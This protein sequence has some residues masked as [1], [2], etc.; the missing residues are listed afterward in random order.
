MKKAY[1]IGT[2]DTKAN[3][4]LFVKNCLQKVGVEC[5]TVDVSTVEHA[6]S[7]DVNL[8]E[9]T[10]ER[11]H[12]LAAERGEAIST[13]ARVLTDFLHTCT[14]IA[15]VLGLG[16]S[17]GTALITTA[18][19][20][21]SIGLPKIMV[22]TMASG[23]VRAYVGVSDITMMNSITDINGINSISYKVLSNA[24]HALAGMLN[25]EVPAFESQKEALGITMFGVTTPCVN[26]VVEIMKEEYDCMVFHATGVG[27]Q[28]MEKLIDSGFIKHVIDA[29][30]TEICDHLMGGVL[31]AGEDRMGAIIR[32]KL[33]YVGS[34]GALDMVNFGGWNTVPEKYKDRKLFKHNDQVTLMRTTV[35]ENIRLGKW[36][37]D[38]LNQMT[39]P[40]RFLLPEKGV[41]VIDVEGQ[42]FYDPEADAALF[43]TLEKEVQQDDFRK[44]IRL[45]YALNDAEFSKALVEAF[46]EI[47]Q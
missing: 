29:T 32:N 16:G 27:G 40:V 13:M 22:S 36:I 3:E 23:D 33:P 11:Q 46:R 28:S 5:T 47:N 35:A 31:S 42:P 41:S 17:G 15:G 2:F 19:Q 18:M 37:A 43:E 26:Q 44:L 7:A 21:L 8:L 6:G 10:A 24:A 45:P 14:D 1:I 20:A 4:L 25:N 30:T 39:A 38:K 12:I 34:V 9:V